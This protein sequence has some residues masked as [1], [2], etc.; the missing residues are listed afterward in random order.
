[1]GLIA[2][3]SRNVL[4]ASDPSRRYVTHEILALGINNNTPLLDTSD[5]HNRAL[6]NAIPLAPSLITC[7]VIIKSRAITVYT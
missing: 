4:D 6:I 3:L 7:W 5:L 2:D 1:M